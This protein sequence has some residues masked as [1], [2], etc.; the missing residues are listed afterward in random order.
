VRRIEEEGGQRMSDHH[1]FGMSRWPAVLDCPCFK[2]QEGGKNAAYGTEKHELFAHYVEST[3]AGFE[4]DIPEDL[5]ARGA[6]EAARALV[7]TVEALGGNKA[8]IRTETRVEVKEGAL[9][10][11]FGTADAVWTDGKTILVCDFK[12]FW[13]AARTYDAQLAG[14]AWAVMTSEAPKAKD[15][16][17]MVCYGDNPSKSYIQRVNVMS[18]LD[19]VNRVAKARLDRLAATEESATQCG[20]C[21][22]CERNTTC[23]ALRKVAEAVATM[24]E[25][26]TAVES[27]SQLPM[28][29]KAQML[30]LAETVCKW[31]D[32]VREKAKQELLEGDAIED[33]ANGIHYTLQHRSGRKTPRP[34]DAWSMLVGRGVN[35]DAIKERLT[36]SASAVKELL[37]TVGVKGKAA[38]ALVEEVSDMGNGSVSMVRG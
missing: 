11:V 35:A 31:A 33:S 4:A 7:A 6:L 17:L 36:I 21:E 30:V 27:W 10:G 20:W 9:E 8:D 26:T 19:I 2:G 22:L 3:K 24:P 28:A 16:A 29:R 32:A 37:K 34:V 1:E 18:L 5:H 14:Y 15:V 12:T 25:I 13:N 23:S 38:D